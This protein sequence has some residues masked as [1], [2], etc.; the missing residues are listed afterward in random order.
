MVGLCFSLGYGLTQRLLDLQLPGFV[1]WGQAFDIREF[2]GTSLESLRLRFGSETQ[3]LRGRLDLQGLEGSDPKPAELPVEPG[4]GVDK[5]DRDVEVPGADPAPIPASGISPASA[6][7]PPAAAK[8]P[9]PQPRLA[10]PTAPTLP[11][12]SLPV[13]Q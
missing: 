6:A 2:P 7:R 11:P 13:Q 1:Q 3:E 8:P 12:P 10:A 4:L 5:L 9:T